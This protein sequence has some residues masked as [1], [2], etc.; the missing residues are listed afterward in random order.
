MGNDRNSY[1]DVPSTSSESLEEEEHGDRGKTPTYWSDEK[2]WFEFHPSA[3]EQSPESNFL[4]RLK[5]KVRGSDSSTQTPFEENKKKQLVVFLDYDGTLSPIVS[6]PD[7]AYMQDEMREA[8]QKVAK[9]F[10]TA[11]VSGRAREK[12]FDFVKLDELYYAGSHGLDIAGPKGTASI[13]YKP[14]LWAEEVMRNVFETLQEKLKAIKGAV[15]ETN[16]FCVSAHYR[17]CENEEDEFEVER[18]VDEIIAKNDSQLRKHT[19]KKVWEVKPK[20]D[21]DKGKALSY[22][23]EALKLNDRTDVISMYLGDDVTDEDAFEVLR[24]LTEDETQGTGIGI[25]VTKVPKQTKASY[26]LRDPSEVLK[27]LLAISEI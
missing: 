20:Y 14:C 21:W 11:I 3:L 8:V 10:P 15:V 24:K 9:K 19:G 25:C 16:V 2:N 12:V 6:Q 18:I 27:F 17:Q 23:L 22:L 4:E 7:K 1:E 26:S 5:E 13:D